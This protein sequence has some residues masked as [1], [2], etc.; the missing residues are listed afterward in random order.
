MKQSFKKFLQEKH[1][2]EWDRTD[3][4]WGREIQQRKDRKTDDLN[5]QAMQ[6]FEKQMRNQDSDSIKKGD[7]VYSPKAKKMYAVKKITAD[8]VYLQ[9]MDRP[10]KVALRNSGKTTDVGHRIF[11]PAGRNVKESTE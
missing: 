2:P 4:D 7:R 6:D 5:P 1:L 11:V 9:G 8:G 10:V 3:L